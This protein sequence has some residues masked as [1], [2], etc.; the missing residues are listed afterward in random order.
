VILPRDDGG[1]YAISLADQE[2][3][4]RIYLGSQSGQ[5]AGTFPAGFDDD[6][7]FCEDDGSGYAILS[8]PAITEDGV[9]IVGTLEGFIYAIGD[10]DW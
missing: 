5:S 9:I 1:L 7:D 3:V 6:D 4:W 2:V 10:R 8:S